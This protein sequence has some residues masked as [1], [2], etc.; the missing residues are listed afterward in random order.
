MRTV[1]SRTRPDDGA[2]P[3]GRIVLAVIAA[4]FIA[5]GLVGAL[6]FIVAGVSEPTREA[7]MDV[8]RVYA[9]EFFKFSLTFTLLAVIPGVIL[10]VLLGGRGVM[11]WLGMGMIFGAGATAGFTWA[12]RAGDDLS[13]AALVGLVFGSGMFLM[14]RW[15]SSIRTD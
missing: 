6:S 14:V 5:T 3:Y 10:L 2:W 8:T 12:M 11:V 9:W 15:L 4:P 13:V 7:V 1:A